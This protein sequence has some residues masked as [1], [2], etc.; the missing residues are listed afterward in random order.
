LLLAIGIWAL[1]RVAPHRP[2]RVV[3]GLTL[4]CQLGLH[5]VYGKETFLYSLHFA[6]LLVILAALGTQT[7]ARPLVLLLAGGLVV[8]A[9]ANNYSQFTKAASFYRS[10]E[11]PRHLVKSQMRVR[12]HD[13]WPRGVGHV[14]LSRPG[15]REEEK[16]YHE[17][18]GSFSP[19]VNTFGV[20]VWTLGMDG[21][22]TSGSE[23]VP[24]Q[25]VRQRFVWTKPEGIPSIATDTPFCRMIWSVDGG[26]RWTLRL[27]QIEGNTSQL[28][29]VIRSVGPAGGPIRHLRWDSTKLLI[30]NRWSVT[31]TPAP[32]NIYLGEEGGKN[33]IS[34]KALVSEW[35]GESGWGNARIELSKANEWIVT[36]KDPQWSPT[37]QRLDAMAPSTLKI[38]LPDKRFVASLDSQLAHL[39]MGLVDRQPRPGDPMN[40]P[41]AWQ[42]DGAYVVAALA[43]AG[44]VQV[45]K[46]LSV[47]LAENDFFGG[48]GTEA[49][50]PGLGIWALEEV[51]VRLNQ[52]EYDRWIWPHVQRKVRLLQE[53]IAT[54]K[55]LYKPFV[56]PVVPIV[57][58]NNKYKRGLNLLC[59]P[60]S[61]GLII[62]KMDWH[63]PVLYVNAV[64]YR[65]LR[66]AADIAERLNHRAEAEGWRAEASMLKKAWEN[67]YKPPESRNDRTPICGLWPTWV[68][69]SIAATYQ[70][71]LEKRWEFLRNDQGEFRETP[72]WTY[73]ALAESHQWLFL[74]R[75]DRVWT[76]LEW[77]WNH[78]ASPGLFTWWEGK[79]DY[80][81]FYR[82][83]QVRGW[84]NPPYVTPHYWTAAEMAMLQLDMLAYFDESA[85]EPTVVIGA[86]IPRDWLDSPMAVRGLLLGV[87]DLDWMWDGKEVRVIV[88]RGKATV[89]LGSAFPPD[90][91]L[92]VVKRR[93]GLISSGRNVR[94]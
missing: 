25:E 20:S 3:L 29:V 93:G 67:G 60:S 89:R 32:S 41:L 43:R 68:G 11:S 66:D 38:D 76:T 2:A 73:F 71:D 13:P 55:P 57:G 16:S 31:V 49:D 52:P 4:L 27:K 79:G 44:R 7:P 90:T 37:Y 30:N 64:S 94:K 56:G 14:I 78:Q 34:D 86:G 51:A 9:A 92:I 80:N 81:T 61:E 69:S 42:R 26:G 48:F 17:P 91:R 84:V 33:W 63:F 77:F 21:A 88:K 50:A 8:V 53:M 40:Y 58:K 82:W 10:N 22:V 39:L 83:E 45:A 18:G 15:D 5:M 54:N 72:F 12:P 6:P 24:P 62:G 46:E 35:T 19:A 87:V 75:P 23:M 28:M 70:K 85:S 1:F 47:Y 65:G 59:K 36:I 74:G